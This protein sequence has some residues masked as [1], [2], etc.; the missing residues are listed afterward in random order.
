MRVPSAGHIEG[1]PPREGGRRQR[2]NRRASLVRRQG[3]TALGWGQD[4]GSK[5]EHIHI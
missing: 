2:V 5:A 3:L 1:R 4:G